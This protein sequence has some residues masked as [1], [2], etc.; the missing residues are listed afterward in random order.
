LM[1][2][3]RDSGMKEHVDVWDTAV[4]NICAFPFEWVSTAVTQWTLFHL[5]TILHG[6]SMWNCL[7]GGLRRVHL[8]CPGRIITAMGALIVPAGPDFLRRDFI[9]LNIEWYWW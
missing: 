3:P 9:A 8:Y 5:W 2:I 4:E 6:P 7:C 1:E